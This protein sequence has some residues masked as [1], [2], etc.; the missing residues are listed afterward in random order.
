MAYTGNAL[1][2]G[3]TYEVEEAH[4]F[5]LCFVLALHTKVFYHEG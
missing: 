3:D 5:N 4:T 1:L 2:A